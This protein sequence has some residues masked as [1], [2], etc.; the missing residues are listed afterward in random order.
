VDT[1]GVERMR[2]AF[3]AAESHTTAYPGAGTP[4]KVTATNGWKRFLDL[5][6][7]IDRVDSASTERSLRDLV[8][9]S[10]SADVLDDRTVA[11]KAYRELL[12][13]GGGWLPGW[14]V[15]RPMGEWSFSLA[16]HRITEA[17]AVLDLRTQVET[18]AAALG[19]H[20]DGA[21]KTAYEAADSSLDPAT[22]LANEELAAVAA[23]ADAKAQV[24][25]EPDLVSRIGLIGATPQVA[26]DAAR[27]AF[28][29]GDIGAA[30]AAAAEATTI[31]AGAAALGQQRLALG[32]G[33]A[34][35][36]LLLVLAAIVLRRRR[37][38]GSAAI[39][40]P[41]ALPAAMAAPATTTLAADPNVAPPST[42]EPPSEVEGGA[43]HGDSPADPASP[44]TG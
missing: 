35:G 10:G 9:P 38:R 33:L 32:I 31:V 39:A 13:A 11:R 5:V 2:A 25:T 14:Y 26:Y 6:E 12:E 8:L 24:E 15:R 16:E 28:E 23:I 17:T 43:T 20:P 7:S 36:L 27:S 29:R 21:L 22:A 42:S 37:R 44:S 4:E 34:L 3:A 19:L 41:M 30:K 1:A 18:A 40:S